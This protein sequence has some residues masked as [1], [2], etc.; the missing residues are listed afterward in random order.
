MIEI[1]F[2][3][4]GGQG[5]V[6]AANLLADAAV[7]AGYNSQAFASYGARRRGGEVESYIRLAEEPILSHSKIYGADYT[8]IMSEDLI[9][10]TQKKG[11]F[12]K[13]ATVVINT[14]KRPKEFSTI[15]DC[16]IVTIDADRI[17][18]N[19]GVTLPSGMPVIN[20]TVLGAL[21]GLLPSVKIDQLVESLQE[22]KL[23]AVEKN[24]EAA[25][26]AFDNIQN[27]LKVTD[28]KKTEAIA[29]EPIIV[30]LIP[31]YRPK[32]APCEGSCPAGEKI[33]RTAFYIQY[34]Y[35]EDALENIRKENP[36]PGICGRVCFHPCESNCNR[37]QYDEGVAINS[38][39]RAAFDFADTS[40]VNR[41]EKKPDT[42]KTVGIIGSGPAGMTCAYYLTL[43]GH[44]VTVIE[45]QSVAGGVPRFGIPE[46]H[47]PREIIDLEIQGIV[48]LGVDIKL[49]TKVGKDITFDVI[50]KEYDATFIATGAHRSVK[51]SIPGEESD[52]V[53]SGLDFLKRVSFGENIPIGNK[54]AVI[55]GGNVAMDVARTARRIG[56][57]EVHAICLES[58]EEMP[59]YSWEITAAEAEGVD[60]KTEWGPK[61]I[62]SDSG[63]ILAI[64]LDRCTSIFDSRG[65]FSPTYDK[66][67]NLKIECDT[68]ITAIG[69]TV[70]LPFAGDT[71][72][73]SG[74]VIEVD[75]LGRTSVIGVYAG[76]DA[77]SLLRS[78][79]EAIAS[80]KRAALGIDL[81][82]TGG[83]EKTAK[84]FQIGKN[85]AVSMSRY[86]SGDTICEVNEVVSY[87]DLNLEQFTENPRIVMAELPA[88]TR[89]NNFIETNFGF[90]KEDAMVEAERC[91]HCGICILCEVCY[92]L[93]PEVAISFDSGK[94]I[95]NRNKDICKSCGI[96]IY[97]CPRN[98]IS[99]E[100]VNSD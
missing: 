94:P 15:V 81:Y 74:P 46:Y 36:F 40:R 3:G 89:V 5:S 1:E 42:G 90:S 11:K 24:I 27:S 58:R 88:D 9:E 83:D 65:K 14:S 77:T 64:E 37:V 76:G 71:V 49:N 72:K 98:A 69:E 86:L 92:I 41:P 21:W 48:D 55:G 75:M 80:G 99:W 33:E 84:S 51:L 19:K 30:G 13:G 20:T 34:E 63:K 59:A 8:I 57:A 96:C 22:G 44:S 91:F 68:V 97:E 47:L 61:Q 66:S 87:E 73:M 60:L 56:A 12:K 10:D 85:G 50:T 78:V 45:A 25:L 29:I 67:T 43:L 35:F 4:T 2:V 82:L 18:V 7:R 23:P 52:G 62:V 28:Q 93:C 38:L 53:F 39:E 6:V 54:V 16:Q 79:V 17:A 32:L 100:G 95:F 26:E 31:E 70:E